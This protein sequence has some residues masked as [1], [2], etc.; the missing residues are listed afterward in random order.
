M[1]RGNVC[2]FVT[3]TVPIIPMCLCGNVCVLVTVPVILVC[4]CGNVCLF[5]TVP[6]ILDHVFAN[7]CPASFLRNPTHIPDVFVRRITDRHGLAAIISRP[8]NLS[9][10]AG[11]SMCGFFF[12]S[13]NTKPGRRAA[14]T[15]T[16]S[17]IKKSE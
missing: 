7:G 3:V 14:T 10:L 12:A 1:A 16:L 17:A 8:V 15:K 5:V 2:I 11:S 4:L 13:F 9:R 6:V